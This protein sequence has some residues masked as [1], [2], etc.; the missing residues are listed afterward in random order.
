M[1]FLV[2]LSTKGANS[3]ATIN[4]IKSGAS[5][6]STLPINLNTPSSFKSIVPAKIMPI[7]SIINDNFKIFLPKYI[8]S[9]INNWSF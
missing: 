2:I 3:Q 1:P 9:F 7:I 5:T 4:P 6:L 8:I